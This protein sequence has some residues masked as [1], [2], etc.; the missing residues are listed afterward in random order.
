V[1][2]REPIDLGIE[3]VA[4]RLARR[5]HGR[6][7]QAR[8]QNRGVEIVEVELHHEVVRARVQRVDRRRQRVVRVAQHVDRAEQRHLAAVAAHEAPRRG[9]GRREERQERDERT[10]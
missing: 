4:E 6:R 5:Q 1:L 2:L 9:I 8:L 10:D 3:H 7:E